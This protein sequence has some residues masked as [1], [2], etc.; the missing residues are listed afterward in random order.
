[1]NPRAIAVFVI[2]DVNQRGK[3]LTVALEQRLSD[4]GE[5]DAHKSNAHKSNVHKNRALISELSYGVLRWQYRL[6][7]ILKSLLKKPFKAKDNDIHNLALVGLYQL[8]YMRVP[9]HAAI[10]ETVCAVKALKKPWAKS[11]INGVLRSYQ[12]DSK[13]IIAQ[14]DIDSEIRYSHP[15]WLID[16]LKDNWPQDWRRI[17]QQNNLQAPM[18]VRV[19]CLKSTEQDYLQRLE[20]ANI[21]AASVFASKIPTSTVAETKIPS[22]LVAQRTNGIK[23]ETAVDVAKLPGFDSGFVSIQDAAAQLAATILNAQEGQRVLDVCAA[24]GGKTAHILEIASKIQELV[25]VDK[26]KQ[27]LCKV[28]Q[29]LKRLGL[30]ATVINGDA[31]QTSG[32]WDNT[33]FDRIL[34]DAP[35]SATG[36]I[37]RHP[38]IKILRRQQDMTQLVAIQ[39]KMLDSV[40]T[41]LKPGGKLLYATCSI[42]KMENED[43]IKAF[44]AGQTDAVHLVIE[45]QQWGRQCEY[46]R[47]IL[48][49]END[50]DGF[51]YALLVKQ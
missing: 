21:P 19:N 40:W 45:T 1:M 48:P 2:T 41:L 44:I 12:R 11:V 26:D 36:V 29:T 16:Q 17:L 24:P 34:L 38:D 47:Q 32:W 9:D 49:G 27:R 43:Q 5:S 7:A 31:L 4:A 46:G 42:L 13:A 15:V 8:I 6:A 33:Q 10:Y 50:M 37:R 23:L 25:A 20:A 30:K 18:F 51:Y 3:S 39:A 35:C 14:I 22:V 28:T